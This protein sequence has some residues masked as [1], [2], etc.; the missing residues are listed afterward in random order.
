MFPT[1]T[2]LYSFFS[3]MPSSP[4]F[5]GLPRLYISSPLVPVPCDVPFFAFVYLLDCLRRSVVW[6]AIA[7][8]FK[9]GIG[10]LTINAETFCRHLDRKARNS[11]ADRNDRL[12]F[13]RRLDRVED[14]T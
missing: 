7:V 2:T 4:T 8:I 1:A 9:S 3:L 12:V 11:A 13:Y 5:V 14:Y 10:I 6:F